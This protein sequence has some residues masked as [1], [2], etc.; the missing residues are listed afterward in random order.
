MNALPTW[1]SEKY[2]NQSEQEF[3]DLMD[4]MTEVAKIRRHFPIR[5]A[6]LASYYKW[7]YEKAPPKKSISQTIWSYTE[8][9]RPCD[10]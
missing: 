5:P 1:P 3:R 10:E 6:V 9:G 8:H 7:F 2:K 4:W